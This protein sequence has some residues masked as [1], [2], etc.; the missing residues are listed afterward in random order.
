MFDVQSHGLYAAYLIDELNKSGPAAPR[1]IALTGSYGS[2]KSSVLRRVLAAFPD[3]AIVI[4]L[5]TLG[6]QT[7]KERVKSGARKGIVP[8]KTNLI[9]KEIVKQLLYVEKPSKMRGS[10]YQRIAPLQKGFAIVA[11]IAIALLIVALLFLTD[12]L[13][14][15]FDILPKEPIVGW[16][17]YGAIFLIV[18]V[19][20]VIVQAKFHDRVRIQEVATGPASIT[21]SGPSDNY[22]DEYL[23]EIV[24]FFEHTKTN[25]VLFEDLDRF[26]NSHIFETLREL[27]TLLNGSKFLSR[28]RVIRFV[29]AIKDSV[30]EVLDDSGRVAGSG[31]ARLQTSR[32]KFFDVVIPLVPFITHRSSASYINQTFAKSGFKLDPRLVDM[33]AAR[34]T[35]MRLI[36][37][38]HN[39]Y[40]IFEQRIFSEGGITGLSRDRLFAMVVYKNTSLTDY[41][42]L[43]AAES[44]LDL[45]YKSSRDLINQNATR[46]ELEQR[47]FRTRAGT[48]A[49]ETRAT[50]LGDQLLEYLTSR[51]SQFQVGAGAYLFDGVE[52]EPG[53][54]RTTEFWDRLVSADLPIQVRYRMNDRFGTVNV[55]DFLPDDLR[56]NLTDQLDVNTWVRESRATLEDSAQRAFAQRQDLL[57]AT[58]ADLF[59]ESDLKVRI[60]GQILALAGF[61]RPVEKETTFARLVEVAVDNPL[62]IDLLRAGHIDLNYAL[63]LSEFKDAHRTANAMNYVVQFVQ[64][65]LADPTYPMS[66]D[67]VESLLN[68]VGPSALENRTLYNTSIFDYLL[69]KNDRRRSKLFASLSRMTDADTNFARQY[70][71]DGAQVA[72]FVKAIATHSNHVMVF[73]IEEF[74]TDAE[75]RSE[76]VTLAL[77]SANGDRKYEGSPEVRSYLSEGAN[78]SLPSEPASAAKSIAALKMLGVQ[79][80]DVEAVADAWRGLVVEND[81]YELSAT[82]L[83]A[84]TGGPDIALD[85]LSDKHPAIAARLVRTLD[86]YLELLDNAEEGVVS[87]GDPARFIDMVRLVGGEDAISVE[88]FAEHASAG[89]VIGDLGVLDEELWTPLVASGRVAPTASNVINYVQAKDEVTPELNAFL[90]NVRALTEVADM[91]LEARRELAARL[92]NQAALDPATRVSIAVS[93]QVG[94]PLELDLLRPQK[95][96]LFGL[97][98]GAGLLDDTSALFEYLAGVGSSARSGVVA[99][100]TAFP[101]YFQSVDLSPED[102]KEIATNVGISRPVRTALLAHIADYPDIDAATAK[103]FA[104]IARAE[105]VRVKSNGLELFARLKVDHGSVVNLMLTGINE[106]GI[107]QVHAVLRALGGNYALLTKPGAK[108]VEVEDDPSNRKLLDWLTVNGKVSSYSKPVLR[109]ALNVYMRRA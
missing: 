59:D 63:Y 108:P 86:R 75:R 89:C 92:I 48:I 87:V 29:Y 107:E 64:Q 73:L 26:E 28:R 45:V 102:L 85:F 84:L 109:R 17:T 34:I 67:D 68:E 105:G 71:A 60:D 16:V 43:P 76:L 40:V 27:N 8:S 44:V 42:K 9:Q 106:R 103:S 50:S 2:G 77:A 66:E 83:R 55:I 82:N 72:A 19:L 95:G 18:G 47:R 53:Y 57:R 93:L 1:N 15:L 56:K 80:V 11:A 35:D 49:A 62:V 100:S 58:M 20:A 79:I 65:E 24:Y 78:Y 38:I 22:F 14:N 46:L 33:V 54:F 6:E 101:S 81:L 51:M 23:D 32:T 4:S 36:K 5:P 13:A 41:E 39:E 88:R 61:A 3:D 52:R 25:I 37:S 90:S 94:A 7:E 104:Q 91:T 31:A 10:R 97:L 99:S 74:E 96:P 69:K 70:L 98:L 30:F 12:A 21:L